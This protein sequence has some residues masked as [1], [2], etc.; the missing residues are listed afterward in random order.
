MMKLLSRLVLL[1]IV[2][3]ICA[4]TIIIVSPEVFGIGSSSNNEET[5]TIEALQPDSP[6]DNELNIE[7]MA[8][9]ALTTSMLSMNTPSTT[10]VIGWSSGPIAFIN[11]PQGPYDRTEGYIYN[12]AGRRLFVLEGVNMVVDQNANPVHTQTTAGDNMRGLPILY[13]GSTQE[14]VDSAGRSLNVWLDSMDR[15]ILRQGTRRTIPINLDNNVVL[16]SVRH[17]GRY[18]PTYAFHTRTRRATI[19]IITN[20]SRWGDGNYNHRFHDVTGNQIPLDTIS[21]RTNWADVSL[22]GI[23]HASRNLMTAIPRL[24]GGGSAFPRVVDILERTT[25]RDLMETMRHVQYH[26]WARIRDGVGGAFVRSADS[27][28]VFVNPRTSQLS[29]R[30]GMP[31]FS[32]ENRAKPIL[33]NNGDIITTDGQ[34]K[35]ITNAILVAAYSQQQLL[36]RGEEFHMAI[37]DTPYGSFSVPVFYDDGRWNTATGDDATPY[38]REQIREVLVDGQSLGE[39]FSGIFGN[40]GRNTRIAL[41]A[42]VW[43]AIAFVFAIVVV[44]PLVQVVV[45]KLS[46]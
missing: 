27:E 33:F 5:C 4:T 31:L 42:I 29:D 46:N 16:I 25:L 14:F 21:Q 9:T 45:K 11:P 35:S 6:W 18:V 39:L 32:M 3:V 17:G 41:T 28:Y 36:Q 38:I 10:E 30:F 20:V 13:D 23:F 24:I 7:G 40:L 22:S 19:N 43:I 15:A 34:P 1:V 26:P 8:K 44:I 37:I 12:D 2:C